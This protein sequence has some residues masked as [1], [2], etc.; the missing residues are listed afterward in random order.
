MPR[1][2]SL[3]A[4]ICAVGFAAALSLAPHFAE[5][6]T[7]T[8]SLDVH[9]TLAPPKIDGVISPGE[10][11]AAAHSDAFR[12]IEPREN[13]P[14]VERTEFWVTY[15]SD[16]VY[17]AVR[18]HD[19][20]G[21][22]GIRAYSMQHDQDNGSDDIV[23]VV[24]D[25]FNRENDGYYFALTAAGGRHEGLIQNKQDANPEWDSIW[26]GR[27]SIDETG[28][29]AEFAIPVKSIAFDPAN[30]TWGFDVARA[31]R[32][33]Q[34]I[35]RWAGR[36]RNKPT[37]SLPNLGTL[38]GIT[39]LKQGRGI[40]FKPFAS[41]TRRSAPGAEEKAND[42]KP[43]FDLVW[44][45]T[46]SL[47][48]TFT[49]NTDFADAEVD[50]R[51][52]NLGRFSLFFPEKR[53]FFTQDASLFAFAGIRQDPMPFFSRRIGLAD[54]GTKVDLLG[55]VKLTGRTGPLTV[56]LLD[57]QTD[58]HGSVDA[59][60]LL[61][62]RVAVQV[63]EESSTGLIFT[64]GDPRSN[65]DNAL[66]GADFN[67]V[68]SHLPG[69]K[70]LIAR[71]AIQGT[72]SDLA[73]GRGTAATLVVDYPNDPFGMFVYF[74]RID[75][76]YDP[77]LGFVPRTGIREH[78]TFAR[79][80]WYPQNSWW[81]RLDL[82]TEISVTTDL[83]G[84]RLDRMFWLPVLEGESKGGDF[85][86]FQVQQSRERLNTPFAIRPGIIIPAGDHAGTQFQFLYFSTRS[87]PVNIGLELRHSDFF[88]G[89][90]NDYEVDLGWRPSSQLELRAGWRL[91]SIRL[92]EGNFDL[93]IGS[94]KA[95]YTF[96]PDL[97]LSLLAQ[98]DNFSNQLGVNLR[99]KW[100][101]QPGNEIFLVVNQG[102]DT[103]L[104][105]FR[106]VQNDTSLKGAWTYRF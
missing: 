51:Q 1:F 43:G 87:R 46:P 24:F 6:K 106:P 94:A 96:S 63:L 67:F 29:N 99:L 57:V 32:R 30:D 81:Q 60:N 59:K 38:R 91:R 73:G 47:A 18:S 5:A 101:V 11:A 8:T 68:N 65:G 54:D 88:T 23:R 9:A 7:G 33:T 70:T 3:I 16:F 77:A 76:K 40:D 93:R 20:A 22:T 10:W 85:I 53:S 79:Y 21:R 92:P 52:V 39:G 26:F 71:A 103:S 74:S 49:V 56:G 34:E 61:V 83:N 62:G 64:R 98:Y 12:Q 31:V 35:M 13:V 82:A 48:A 95:V 44:N 90:R 4:A 75:G 102:Y 86:G 17:I 37:I 45:V 27:T 19:S 69:N 25:T 14:P 58:A 41:F 104:D 42:F 97:Q 80:R 72:D 100:I 105:R 89:Q 55:G 2:R 15:D 50:E 78:H 66:V 84:R 36:A 28:W